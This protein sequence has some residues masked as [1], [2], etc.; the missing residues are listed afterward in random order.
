[1]AL[2]FNRAKMTTATTGTGT[3]TL[4][5]AVDGYQTFA[6]AGV[7]DSDVV[8]YVIE[9]GDNWEI[10]EGTYTASGTTLTRSVLESSNADS[11]ISLSGDAQVFIGLAAGDVPSGRI[12]IQLFESSGTYTP[13]SWAKY[14]KITCVGAGGGG[15]GFVA[16]DTFGSAGGGG[17]GIAV[18]YFDLSGIS[19]LSV[20]IGSGGGGGTGAGAGSAGG[21]SQVDNGGTILARAFGGGGGAR[22]GSTSSSPG[23]GGGASSE[24]DIR[25]G[26]S[27]SLGGA[28]GN[29]LGGNGASGPFGGARKGATTG[30]SALASFF[31]SGGHGA[32]NGAS[33]GTGGDGGDGF[34]LFEEF[35]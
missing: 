30:G 32:F 31:G 9:D 4:G 2:L 5:S 10:G 14:V 18:D 20:T 24:A 17:G 33:N 27:G 6:A 15:G 34:V 3:I 12:G 23:A 13:S 29:G 25:P 28:G 16:N 19:S 22:S 21:T 11:A 7:S 26:L 1:M 8:R 35:G